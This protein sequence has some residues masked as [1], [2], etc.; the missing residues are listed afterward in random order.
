MRNL[1]TYE[2]DIEEVD[3]HNDIIDHDH[4]DVLTGYK[5]MTFADIDGKK[6]VLVL[7][8]NEGNDTNGIQ[9]RSWAYAFYNLKGWVLPL[10]TD[11]GEE[12]PHKYHKE[13]ERYQ[14]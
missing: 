10:V 7:V 1:I 9:G 4:Q 8:R 6:F 13:L 11:T 2:W 14:N 3:E 5:R 12:I